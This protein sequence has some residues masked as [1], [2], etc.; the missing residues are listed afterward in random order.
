MVTI[1]EVNVARTFG[2]QIYPECGD[3]LCEEQIEVV[4]KMAAA[5]V[6]WNCNGHITISPLRGALRIVHQLPFNSELPAQDQ[7]ELLNRI[8][9]VVTSWFP[10]QT[11]TVLFDPVG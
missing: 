8:A 3:K 1:Y 4:E 9:E 6:V 7:P 10:H 2:R 11:V 5:R